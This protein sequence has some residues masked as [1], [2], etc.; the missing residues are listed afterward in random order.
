MPPITHNGGDGTSASSVGT[1][2]P[3]IFQGGESGDLSNESKTFEVPLRRDN[4]N[5]VV[6]TTND[7]S[8]GKRMSDIY[9]KFSVIQ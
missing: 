4:K 9:R 5:D 3:D 8:T 7:L 2:S 1:S 6:I